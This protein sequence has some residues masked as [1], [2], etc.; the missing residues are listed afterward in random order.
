MADT[1]PKPLD[2]LTVLVMDDT[3]D[4][5]EVDAALT[6]FGAV[7]LRA[8][9]GHEGLEQLTREQIDV[10]ISDITMPTFSGHDFINAVRALAS[11]AQHPV[12]AI[13]LTAV[14]EP[15]QRRRALQGG[16]QAYWLKPVDLTALVREIARLAGRLDSGQAWAA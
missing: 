6:I 3:P 15:A 9:N 14:D 4:V 12:P 16:F 7:V 10:I 2:G 1:Y 13:A 11:D 5:H 8:R